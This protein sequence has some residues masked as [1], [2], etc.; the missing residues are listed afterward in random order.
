[1]E[2]FALSL[3]L[4]LSLSSAGT[5]PW[6]EPSIG[7]ISTTDPGSDKRQGGN[8]ETGGWGV[9]VTTA[10]RTGTYAT[11]TF[12]VIKIET[13]S[14][15]L[16][17]STGQKLVEAQD[18]FT[19]ASGRGAYEQAASSE[20]AAAL[21][22]MQQQH[23]ESRRRHLTWVT[24]PRPL[25]LTFRIDDDLHAHDAPHCSRHFTT[26]ETAALLQDVAGCGSQARRRLRKQ[27]VGLHRHFTLPH[28]YPYMVARLWQRS[29][30]ESPPS[31]AAIF[32]RLAARAPKPHLTSC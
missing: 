25:D 26:D 24:P 6:E 13:T 32:G 16:R 19:P 22:M 29:V 31:R 17:L 9:Y 5:E 10:A 30:N 8:S 23:L 7:V 12:A 15:D 21:L 20:Q 14:G 4:S 28:C 3:S 11:A 1:M 18:Q 2:A 27:P